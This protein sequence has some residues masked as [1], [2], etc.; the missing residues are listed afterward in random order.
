M[1]A[2][3]CVCA[4]ATQYDCEVWFASCDLRQALRRF[5]L[6]SVLQAVRVLVDAE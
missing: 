1:L 4:K 5:H 2:F 6:Q 3:D